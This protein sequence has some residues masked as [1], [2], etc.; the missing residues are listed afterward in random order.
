MRVVDV[1]I[2]VYAH[3][4][5]APDHEAM[6]SWLDAARRAPRPLGLADVVLAGFLRLVTNPRVFRDPT[7]LDEAI[8][9]VD[10][11]MAG[12]AVRRIA[13]GERHWSLFT[14]LC[15]RAGVKGNLVPDAYL[16]ALALEQGAVL[17]TADR[18][19]ARFPEVRVENPL[20]L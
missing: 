7:A 17:V 6:R 10:A 5:E 12:P 18:D 3:R 19:F 2:L 20:E 9:F 13:P 11:L 8:R 15:R 1:N 4:R 14:D 16:A